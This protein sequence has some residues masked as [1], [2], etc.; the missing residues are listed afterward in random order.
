MTCSRGHDVKHMHT[1]PC[2]AR[3]CLECQ[4]EYQR[5]RKEIARARPAPA[6]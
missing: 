1:Y 4:R 6:P 2:G 3:R 5:N